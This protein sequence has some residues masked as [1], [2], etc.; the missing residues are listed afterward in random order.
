MI[1]VNCGIVGFDVSF[2]QDINATL[3]KI[4]FN[5]MIQFGASFVIIKTGQDNYADED[6]TDNWRNAKQA[7]IPRSAYWFC[8]KDRGGKEQAILFWNLVKDDLPEGM[9]FADF[10]VGSWTGWVELYNFLRE[11][12]ALSGL[13][14]SRIGIYTGY[15][16]W[17]A[18][19]PTNE[20]SRNWFRQ[21]PLWL[22]AYASKPD[23]VLVP[24]P[25]TECLIW[26]D[27]TPPIGILAGA[28]SKEIDHNIFNGD[29][30]KFKQYMGGVPVTPPPGENMILYYADL[31]TGATSNVRSGPGL[32]YP[33]GMKITGPLTISIISEKVVADG[34]DWYQISSPVAGWI[35]Y[36]TSYTNFRPAGTTPPPTSTTAKATV[37]MPDG[38]I[39][40]GELTKQ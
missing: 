32:T 33:V 16:Y 22:A 39:W 7:G 40:K 26:Q 23:L 35:A 38:T 29:A 14:S 13:P 37:E 28:E 6:F 34:Y 18:Y 17:R 21:F 31:K 10:E 25:W 3:R 27:G 9:L 24:S 2:Y 8:D 4:D 36:T 30:E 11:L 20:A 19:C 12:K 15:Y 1:F 5:Q